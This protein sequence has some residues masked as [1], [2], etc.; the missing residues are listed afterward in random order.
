MEPLTQ[1]CGRLH[2]LIVHLPIGIIF[3]IV[4]LEVTALVRK[5]RSSFAVQVRSIRPVLL[6]FLAVSATAAACCGWLLS[7]EG[8]YDT[9][10]LSRHQLA[11]FIVAG[12]S[13]ALFLASRRAAIYG[14]GLVLGLAAVAVAGH[15]GGVLTHGSGYLGKPLERLL[16]ASD[17]VRSV[18]M[19]PAGGDLEPSAFHE[20]V[21]PVLEDRCLSCHGPEKQRGRLRLD[22]WDSIAAGGKHGP[23][24]LSGDPAGSELIRRLKLPIEHD[25]HMPPKSKP[26][27]SAR[28]I[29]ILE[30]WIAHGA[31]VEAA[32]ADLPPI[33]GVHES[34]LLVADVAPPPEAPADLPE[35][36]AVAQFIDNIATQTGAVINY[37]HPTEPWIEVVARYRGS[38]FDNSSLQYLLPV[39]RLIMNLDLGNTAI[40]DAGLRAVAGMPN[41]RSLKLDETGITDAGLFHLRSLNNLKTLNLVATNISDEGL[42]ALHSLRNLR[43]VHIWRTNTSAEAVSD[44]EAALTDQSLVDQLRAQLAAL[45]DRIRTETPVIEVGGFGAPDVQPEVLKEE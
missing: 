42:L 14:S 27:P 2:P 29:K 30:W 18:A 31:S 20:L 6:F 9:E 3:L 32:R 38:T 13:I 21:F 8:G 36:E 40:T 5:R 26:Q 33:P 22:S 34:Q 24:V 12:L 4:F 35:R 15:L 17:P 10:T 37:L 11:G 25:E 1:L 39:S 19:H 44:L 28:E 43:S 16:S 23:V 7:L 41:L 45:Q